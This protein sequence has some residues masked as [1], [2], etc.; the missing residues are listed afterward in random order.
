MKITVIMRSKN[1]AWVIGQ[2][3]TALFAQQRQDFELLLVDSGSTDA[4]L[5]IAGRFPCRVVRIEARDYF[6]GVV[7]NSAIRQTQAELLV[8]QNSDTVPLDPQA[9][10]R[11]LEPIE[12]GRADATFAR[13]LPRPEAHTW[14]VRDHS[15]S[16]PPRGE[17]PTWMTYSLPFA[18]MRRAAWERHPF[19]E[20]AWGSEDTEWGHWARS[21]GLIVRYLPEVRVMHSHNYTLRQLYGRR[22]I[23]GEADA[24][25]L[26]DRASLPGVVRRLGGSWGRDVQAH[27]AAGDVKGLL[28]SFPRRF[29]YHWAWWQGNRLGE[30]RKGAGNPDASIGQR[31]VLDRQ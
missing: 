14:V 18:A 4:T 31:V 7:L 19:Y 11:L 27:L 12:S 16:F 5:D 22:F 24:F 30:R 17:A 25:I 28:L 2:A 6:P 1:S 8:F 29:V 10:G 26:P 23:E 21:H 9:L 3:L 20:E 15:V 13:Q